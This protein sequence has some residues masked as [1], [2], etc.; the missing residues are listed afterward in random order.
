MAKNAPVK[1]GGTDNRKAVGRP[2][3]LTPEI[4]AT[5][6][7]LLRA[8]NYITTVADF[9]GINPD[10]IYEWISRGERGWKIDREGGFVEFSETVK[11]AMSEVEMATVDEVRKGFTNWQSRAWFLERRYPAKWGAQSKTIVSGPGDKPIEHKDVTELPETLRVD[12]LMALLAKAQQ[13]QAE[14]D[15]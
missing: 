10:T 8:G 14:G 2:S 5:I 1:D 6:A 7:A 9:V 13:R 15:E 3:K 12:R 11:K 4:T